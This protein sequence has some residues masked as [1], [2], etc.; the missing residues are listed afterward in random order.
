MGK[1]SGQLEFI[2]NLKAITGSFLLKTPTIEKKVVWVINATGSPRNLTKENA[3]LIYNLVKHDLASYSPYGGI[4]VDFNTSEVLNLKGDKI[5]N[6]YAIGHIT[7]GTFLYTPIME[8]VVRHADK[9]VKYA[10]S[11]FIQK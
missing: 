1:K 3:P 11:Q 8:H 2:S 4:N 5:L 10:F 7:T 9:I 6:M